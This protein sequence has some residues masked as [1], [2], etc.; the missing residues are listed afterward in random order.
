MAP[1]VSVAPQTAE[2]AANSKA[3]MNVSKGKRERIGLGV[4]LCIA[5]LMFFCPLA[6]LHGAFAGDKTAN[7]LSVGSE[8]TLL[9]SGLDASTAQ[10]STHV[11]PG[12]ASPASLI[13]PFSVRTEWLASLFIF[14]ALTCAALALLDL[15]SFQ[16]A[17]AALGLA[18]GCFGA[19][20]I[21]QLVMINAGVRVW[22]A[23]LIR[24]GAFGSPRDPFV[25]MRV[26][27]ARSFE[28]V[29]GPGLYVLTAC[30]FLVSALS[31]SGAITRI[32]SVVRRSPRVEFSQSIRVRPVDAEY[33]PETCSTVDISKEGLY[34]E[35]GRQHYYPGMEVRLTRNPQLGDLADEEERASV[36]RV[37]QLPDGTCGVAVRIISPTA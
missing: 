4:I 22:T 33:P 18:G 20:A 2:M 34:F 19:L 31:Y 10:Y 37:N 7:G 12:S 6:N 25:A 21:L 15:L 8:L 29:P 27:I 11:A 16:K 36:V 35:T 30:L 5:V 28:L 1:I 32:E 3:F 23:E 26:L 14:A 17:I 24:S 13:V 9:R